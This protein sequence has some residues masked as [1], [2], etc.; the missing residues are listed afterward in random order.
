MGVGHLAAPFA[1]R[2]YFRRVPFFFLL[3]AGS[4]LDVL[5]GFSRKFASLSRRIATLRLVNQAFQRFT[6][7]LRIAT[8]KEDVS[9]GT[10]D[11]HP[12]APANGWHF[13]ESG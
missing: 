1:V 8:I 5:W 9:L 11:L 12:L 4:F 13:E 7:G 6:I 3:V 10:S 2:V